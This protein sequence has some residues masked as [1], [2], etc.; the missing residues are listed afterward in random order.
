MAQYKPN[1]KLDSNFG[2]H[3]GYTLLTNL[4]LTNV[5]VKFSSVTITPSGNIVVAGLYGAN[6]IVAQYKPDGTLDSS[7][8]GN[9]TG[10]ALFS[11][12]S[13]YWNSIA[14]TSNGNIVVA[15]YGFLNG[16]VDGVVAQYKPDG[17][18]DIIDFNRSS[19]T[20]GYALFNVNEKAVIWRTVA[21]TPNGSIVV[22]GVLDPL[23]GIVTQY[24]SDGTLDTSFGGNNTGY[25]LFNDS[26]NRTNNR[27]KSSW[28]SVAITKDENI[29]VAGI[30]D[31]SDGIVTQYKPNGTL[32]TAN[33]N[34]RARGASGYALL[35]VSKTNILWNS[36]AITAG[37]N[38]V[39]TGS[40][41]AGSNG[42][43]G[44]VA[45]Y[46]GS[47]QNTPAGFIEKY[48]GTNLGLLGGIAKV[49]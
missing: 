23:N 28:T 16:K 15:G 37:G 21:I 49:N 36:V 6:G 17:T 38:I 14:I 35:S 3:E 7:F 24:K 2:D 9:N 47:H 32:D 27:T 22:A 40:S 41:D 48:S 8:G 39:V 34:A 29:V 43:D 19:G 26:I 18:L 1:G 10:Y 5:A 44:A 31:Q 20:P 11:I 30:Y 45:R 13:I 33:F 25:V 46:F 4:T 12:S 42:S